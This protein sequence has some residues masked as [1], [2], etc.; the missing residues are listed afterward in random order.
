MLEKRIPVIAQED[1][2]RLSCTRVV[3]IKWH[4]S[5]AL[6][7]MY[8]HV[9]ARPLMVMYNL[10]TITMVIESC[11]VHVDYLCR[12]SCKV[13]L[14][15][16]NGNVLL[17]ETKQNSGRR[18]RDPHVTACGCNRCHRCPTADGCKTSRKIKLPHGKK[19]MAVHA[20]S[21]V[22]KAATAGVVTA[23]E[24]WLPGQLRWGRK[25]A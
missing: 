6:A 23:R 7:R 4:C 3:Q 14:P 2:R 13:V 20:S 5:C 12:C 25:R 17:T 15:V 8:S 18:K 19:K 21:S 9:H 24:R 11:A 10:V 1:T 16:S 22:T